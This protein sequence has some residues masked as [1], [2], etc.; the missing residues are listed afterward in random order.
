[1]RKY[2]VILSDGEKLIVNAH[3]WGDAVFEVNVITGRMI[4]EI[5]DI[6]DR[7]PPNPVGC[8]GDS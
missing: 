4:R 5:R 2:E 6:T 1:M 7:I 8:A 3:D